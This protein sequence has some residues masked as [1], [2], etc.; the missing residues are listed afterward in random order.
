MSKA[1][2]L[3]VAGYVRGK[4]RRALAELLA[5]RRKLKKK[6]KKGR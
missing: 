5:H 2:D 6:K 1:M 4:D 3:I